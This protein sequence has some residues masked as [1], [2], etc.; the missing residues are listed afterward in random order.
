MCDIKYEE[1]EEIQVTAA[2][3]LFRALK[4]NKNIQNIEDFWNFYEDRKNDFRNNRNCGHSS[5]ERQ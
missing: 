5:I 3:T 4:E 2:Y 1:L